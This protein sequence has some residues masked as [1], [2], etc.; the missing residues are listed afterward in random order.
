MTDALPVPLTPHEHYLPPL[1]TGVTQSDD[2]FF[3]WDYVATKS[4]TETGWEARL[5][6]GL[7]VRLAVTMP[8]EFEGSRHHT[9]K[10]FDAGL[11]RLA[12]H[13]RSLS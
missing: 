7:H 6:P 10:P 1:A 3:V 9:Y 13:L 5:H 12:E 4:A 11:H 2:Q 8:F